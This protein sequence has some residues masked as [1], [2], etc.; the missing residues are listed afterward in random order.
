VT[1]TLSEVNAD[2]W[3]EAL[4]LEVRPEQMRFVAEY[5][6]IVAGALAKAYIRPYDLIWLPYAIYA[7]AQLVGFME[8]ACNPATENRYWLYHFFIDQ[9]Y[10]GHG[11]GK[12]ALQAFIQ[13]VQ[14][15]YPLCQE[16][17]LSVHPE[18]VTAV[19]LY[20]QFG[21]QP[22][23]EVYDNGELVYALRFSTQ[24]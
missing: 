9:R 14:D 15:G 23:G 1:I 16:I 19:R 11:Y 3:R 13:L 12:Q 7:D 21:F 20:S 2:N 10:Q 6:P 8:L 4:E 24:M 22:T 5:A 18:N 17:R